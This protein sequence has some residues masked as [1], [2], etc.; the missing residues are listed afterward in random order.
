MKNFKFFWIIIS[1]LPI[2]LIVLGYIFPFQFFKNQESIREFVTG[3]GIWAPFGFIGIQIVQVIITPISHYTVSL[4]GGYLFGIWEGFI[5]NWIG[6]VVGS[7]L[8]FYISRYFYKRVITRTVNPDF[9]KKYNFYFNKGLLLLFMAYVLPFFPDDELTYLAGI[10]RIRP[11]IFLPI[12]AIGHSVG[13]LALAYYGHGVQSFSEPLFIILLA[14]LVVGGIL[15][16]LQYR[17]IKSKK[18]SIN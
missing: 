4:A 17:Y 9:I 5:Y 2:L 11:K 16:S 8:A 3:L 10:S 14:I 12:M 13:S 6:R 1:A 15:F 18:S 7:I